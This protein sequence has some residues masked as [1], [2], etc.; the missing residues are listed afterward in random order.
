[1]QSDYLKRGGRAQK[2]RPRKSRARFP[3]KAL[4][5][6]PAVP[7]NPEA[8]PPHRGRGLVPVAPALAR[9]KR[10]RGERRI[11]AVQLTEA[12]DWPKVQG[13]CNVSSEL[14]MKL[15]RGPWILL[16]FS[17]VTT[18]AAYGCWRQFSSPAPP[19]YQTSSIQ[20]PIGA[21]YPGTRELMNA[22]SN[23]PALNN[24]RNGVELRP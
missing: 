8:G 16:A 1:L 5:A 12:V 3:A 7:E 22:P 24:D 17:S 6:R 15:I 13:T 4:L 9:R 14:L 18:A 20:S 23:D 2:F 10:I 11:A 19:L 21:A